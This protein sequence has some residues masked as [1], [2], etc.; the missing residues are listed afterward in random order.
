M[1]PA[2][3]LEKAEQINALITAQVVGPLMILFAGVVAGRLAKNI[4]LRVGEAVELDKHAKRFSRTEVKA[5]EIIAEATA[6]VIYTVSVVWALHLAGVLTQAAWFLLGALVALIAAGLLLYV[7]DILPDFIAGRK[8]KPALKE[9][10]DIKV[11]GVGGVIEQKEALRLRVRAPD[12]WYHIPYRA[13]KK[14][15]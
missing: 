3:L 4:L 2:A 9:G 1:D 13:L 6:A 15:F 14:R 12:G 8:L 11:Q 5:T 7:R 10:D